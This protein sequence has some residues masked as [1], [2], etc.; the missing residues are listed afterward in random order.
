[1]FLASYGGGESPKEVKEVEGEISVGDMMGD[2]AASVMETPIDVALST[3][4]WT[5]SMAGMYNHTG[6]I[7]GDLTVKRV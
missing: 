2:D 7:S 5:G 1:M 4:E 6:T 3:V